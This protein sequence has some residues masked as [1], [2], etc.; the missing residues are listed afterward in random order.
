MRWLFSSELNQAFG[1]TV[2]HACLAFMAD[3][4]SRSHPR[5]QTLKYTPTALRDELLQADVLSKS[6]MEAERAR[7]MAQRRD[8]SIR[9]TA[10]EKQSA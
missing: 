4:R 6:F 3:T 7:R 9:A 8:F 1:R 10:G 5:L 2:V